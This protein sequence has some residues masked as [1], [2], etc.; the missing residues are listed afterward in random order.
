VPQSR[1]ASPRGR[2]H[3]PHIARLG[4][5]VVLAAGH[6]GGWALPARGCQRGVVRRATGAGRPC[7]GPGP[8]RRR[9]GIPVAVMNSGRPGDPNTRSTAG[10]ADRIVL[11][12]PPLEASDTPIVPVQRTP[13]W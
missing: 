7:A 11:S 6:G 3:L 8:L 10:W 13:S 2:P 1:E 5:S 12:G 4:R 9:R